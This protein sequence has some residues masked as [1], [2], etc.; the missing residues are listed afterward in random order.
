[1][2]IKENSV[3]NSRVPEFQLNSESGVYGGMISVVSQAGKK[4]RYVCCSR[5]ISGVC[6]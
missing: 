4:K 6:N 2:V 1:V 5:V 3:Q